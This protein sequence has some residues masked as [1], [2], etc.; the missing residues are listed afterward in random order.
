M[1]TNRCLKRTLETVGGIG[2]DIVKKLIQVF[3]LGE[4]NLTS[5][6]EDAFISKFEANGDSY[7]RWYPDADKVYGMT[8]EQSVAI[9]TALKD[10][11]MLIT[12]NNDW[13]HVL[14]HCSW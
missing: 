2:I 11:G 9:D 10:L 1:N 12:E 4:L 8:K 14:I 5:D 7:H 13:F 3:D 6:V